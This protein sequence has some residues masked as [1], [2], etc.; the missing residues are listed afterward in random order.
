[1]RWIYNFFTEVDI[2]FVTTEV[3]KLYIHRIPL[4]IWFIMYSGKLYVRYG[5]MQFVT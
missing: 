2:H 4:D 3:K 5:H 1:M